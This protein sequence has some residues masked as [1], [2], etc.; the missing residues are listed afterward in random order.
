MP[1]EKFGKPPAVSE[2]IGNKE[3]A[4]WLNMKFG[5]L[6]GSSTRKAFELS[7]EAKKVMM[8]VKEEIPEI[9]FEEI[10]FLKNVKLDRILENIKT[11]KDNELNPRD[12]T[13]VLGTYPPHVRANVENLIR[14]NLKVKSFISL[15]PHEPKFV[16]ED[17]EKLEERNIDIAHFKARSKIGINPEKFVEFLNSPLKE[18]VRYHLLSNKG[19]FKQS[20]ENL[21]MTDEHQALTKIF[22]EMVRREREGNGKMSKDEMWEIFKMYSAS[23]RNRMNDILLI[24]VKD[25][26]LGESEERSVE[27]RRY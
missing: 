9:T 3:F 17:L 27:K 11:F 25:G 24:F 22:E 19:D 2:E 15:L 21:G 4:E 8:K 12:Y 14:R 26:G 16:D 18:R 1:V 6:M 5:L 7:Q 20:I 10:D 23:S 13:H